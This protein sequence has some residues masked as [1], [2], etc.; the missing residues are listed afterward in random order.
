GALS[1]QEDPRDVLRLFYEGMN[2]LYGQPGYISLSVRG[3][4]T[5]QYRVTRMLTE[6]NGALR[7]HTSDPWSIINTMPVHTGGFLGEIIRSAYPEIIHHLNVPNDPVI[8][9]ALAPYG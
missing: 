9:T 6:A 8:G 1:R 5:G 2:K 4:Q 3:L 7:I